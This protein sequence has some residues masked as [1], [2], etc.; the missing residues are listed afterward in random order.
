MPTQGWNPMIADFA[1]AQRAAHRSEGTIRLYRYRISDL[2]GLASSPAKVTTDQLVG[3]LSTPGWAAETRK[4]VRGA[5]RCFFRWGYQSGRLD[6]DPSEALPSVRVPTGVARPA[7]ETVVAAGLGADDRTRFMVMLAAFAGLRACEIA[8]VH[9]DDLTGD[10]L[11]VTGKG[12]KTREL[13]VVHAGLL[14]RLQDVDGWAF[15]NGHGSHLT[16]GHVTKLVSAVLPEGWTAH[17]LRH[18]M[19]TR[20]YAGS[21]DLLAVGALLGHA[22]PETTQRYVRMPDDALRAA[23][24]QAAA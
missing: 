20:A 8:R 21:R 12:G 17:T 19:A 18:R 9:S 1:A 13:P 24:L 15:P 3:V 6:D 22:R 14:A 11:R 7:P 10:I 23:A 5:F 2:C 4:S 16:P